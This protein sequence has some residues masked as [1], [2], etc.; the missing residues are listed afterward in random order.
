LAGRCQSGEHFQAQQKRTAA[1]I[2]K[3]SSELCAAMYVSMANSSSGRDW[4][5]T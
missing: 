4:R 2:V 1:L 5:L 3:Q